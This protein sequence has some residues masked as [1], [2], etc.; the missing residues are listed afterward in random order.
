MSYNFNSYFSILNREIFS[1]SI[2]LDHL[3][4]PVTIPCGHNYCI[5]CI[6][7]HW[8]E[9]GRR[10]HS[11]PQCRKTFTLRPEIK[12]T[13]LQSCLVCHICSH[14]KLIGH[15]YHE[16]V[17]VEAERTKKQK[18]L[19]MSRQKLK[20][21]LRDRE[22]DVTILQQEVESINQSA[23][24]AVEENEKIFAELICLMQNR[25]SDLK[26]QI[27]SQQETEVGRVKELQEKVEQ[28]IAE[29][30][31]NDAKLEQLSC[32][33]DHNQFLHSYSLLSALN[34]ST[35]SSS[36][37]IR[38]L[39]YFED[40]T[41]AV[42]EVSDK[43][44]DV[45]KEKWTNISLTVTEV[46]VLLSEPVPK[47]RVGFLRYSREIRM[48]LNT[49]NTSVLLCEGGRKTTA[50]KEQQSYSSHPDR[51]TGWCQV[52]SRESLTGRCYWEVEWSGK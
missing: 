32:T 42:K 7:T 13:G 5:N 19:E 9:K 21:R 40:L 1:C 36:I 23:D 26:Q 38:P 49:A 18:E 35:D 50:V 15:K 33:E 44:Q 45:L 29:L 20:Q 17:P 24:K 11:C 6:K 27:R 8:D 16:T 34:E 46:D 2:C 43:L 30:R 41:A 39:R 14:C 51:F 22:K 37:E 31:R 28:E 48:D 52:M 47:T 10:M 3:E 4:D 25:S 12:K